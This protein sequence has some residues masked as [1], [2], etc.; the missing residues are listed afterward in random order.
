[1]RFTS[2][3]L[4]NSP[5]LA[6]WLLVL[7]LTASLAGEPL[8]ECAED[9]LLGPIADQEQVAAHRL[10]KLPVLSY[11]PPMPDEYGVGDFWL[12]LVV[13]PSG[14]I[15]CYYPVSGILWQKHTLE[16]AELNAL[17]D[18]ASW[19]Y[20]PFIVDGTPAQVV[21]EEY[22]DGYELPIVHQ[23]A[24]DVPL[25]QVRIR[26]EKFGSHRG[27]APSYGVELDG[28]GQ[29]QYFGEK[30]VD[31]TG[32]H[33]YVVPTSM[34]AELQASAIDNNLWSLNERYDGSWSHQQHHRLTLFFGDESKVIEEL[35]NSS[36]A[37]PGLYQF[38]DA[39]DAAAQTAQWIDLSPETIDYLLEQ[40]FDFNS[41]AAEEL[42]ARAAVNP[43]ADPASL[44]RLRE[45]AA[46]GKV[47]R[48]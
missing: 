41:V 8:R 10:F 34:V 35:G 4:A 48:D 23:A 36:N 2:R 24:P 12:K 7:P 32:H 20:Q 47:Y 31:V 44:Q 30:H 27:S 21:V 39:V 18:M 1:M 28:S 15:T 45:L 5:G 25:E 14:A 40:G 38:I 11:P 22:I 26:L 16:Q 46:E 33:S 29:V 9:E 43:D 42:L 17:S 19:Q 13:D 3:G 37:P 6:G